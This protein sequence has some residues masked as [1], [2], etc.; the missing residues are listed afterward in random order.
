MK[1]LFYIVLFIVVFVFVRK[2]L[3]KIWEIWKQKKA[4]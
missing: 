1:Y 2:A 4:K 3:L